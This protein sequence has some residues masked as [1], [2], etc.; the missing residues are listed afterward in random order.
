VAAERLATRG[1]DGGPRA[2]CLPMPGGSQA[3]QNYDSQPNERAS[4]TAC[5]R[6][7]TSSF[8]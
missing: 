6:E 2:G 1:L 8:L 5:V 3:R 4:N 7:L